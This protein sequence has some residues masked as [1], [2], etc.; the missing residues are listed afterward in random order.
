MRPLPRQH[1][2]K[3]DETLRVV[4]VGH[5][6]HGKSTL[7]GRL[8]YET[9]TLP[10]G[11]FEELQETCKRRGM[12]FEWAFLTDALQEERN[13]GVTI[14]TAQIWF[15]TDRRRYVLVDA[16][17]HREFLKNM[18]TGATSSDAA[19]LLVDAAEGLKEQTRRHA[20]LLKLLGVNETVAIINKMDAV[21]YSQE[22]FRRLAEELETFLTSLGVVAL[23]T[24]PVSA[25]NGDNIKELSPE[26]P[27]WK[28]GTVLDALDG[29]PAAATRDR[30]PLRLPIQD[31]Y[32]FDER[33]I[34]AGRLESGELKVGDKIAFFPGERSAVVKTIEEGGQKAVA[35]ENIGITLTEQIF[36]ERGDVACH[37]SAPPSDTNIIRARLFWLGKSPLQAG[38]SYRLRCGTAETEATVES[39]ENVINTDTLKDKKSKLVETNQVGEII[40]N[41]VHTLAV[42]EHT[43]NPH[44]GRFVLFAEHQ[45]VGGGVISLEGYPKHRAQTNKNE[46]I[47]SVSHR[48]TALNRTIRNRHRPGILWLTGLSASG[49]STIALEAEKQL[50]LKGYQVYALD[51]DNVRKGLSADLGFSPDDRSEN[52]RRIAQVAGLFVESGGLVLVS[53]ISPYRRDRRMAKEVCPEAFHEVYIKASLDTCARRDPK[54]LYKK[55][56]GGR[57][58][59]FSGVSAP[60]E[61]PQ[62]PQLV[63]NTET[64][65]SREATAV[66]AEYAVKTFGSRE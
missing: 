48:V 22:R 7:V 27:W 2:Q 21:G 46:N 29:F 28:G 52:I 45:I 47:F 13:Q 55:A 23:Q 15:A 54:G 57:L 62:N 65:N 10:E 18:I 66:L 39:V 40:L 34:L 36:V 31:I 64:L 6:D 42:D 20:Y 32:K 30:L 41:T 60:Y 38:Q 50:F 56:I 24:I 35:G 8:F 59:D 61:E 53:C 11:K 63:I 3:S 25:K 26:M 51:G 43:A 14:D 5:V 16:P 33:R 9:D 12:P 19:L 4:I 49:K 37:P 17:G 44:N 1:K 58:A